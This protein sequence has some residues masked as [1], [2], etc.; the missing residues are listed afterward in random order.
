MLSAFQIIAHVQ[1]HS[2]CYAK[3]MM[4]D[5]I[6]EQR[7]SLAR[8]NIL[9]ALFVESIY[10]CKAFSPRNLYRLSFVVLCYEGQ[11]T[12][13]LLMDISLPCRL[14]QNWLLP[15]PKLW[16]LMSLLRS[17]CELMLN[18]SQCHSW[19]YS[20]L[21]HNAH[22]HHTLRLLAHITQ[23]GVCRTK[24]LKQNTSTSQ[25]QLLFVCSRNSDEREQQW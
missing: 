21:L 15:N 16:K 20:S 2:N 10:N 6:L 18:G 3:V 25:L 17:L 8:A 11:T 24:Q 5:F 1:Q 19:K 23:K 22:H 7:C 14:P 4:L 13:S 9:Y 12:I